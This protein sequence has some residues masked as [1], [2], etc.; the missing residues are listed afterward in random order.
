MFPS[1]KSA[2]KPWLAKV[3]P[4]Q[5]FI[6]LI[7]SGEIRLADSNNDVM[8]PFESVLYMENLYIK[9]TNGIIKVIKK[10]T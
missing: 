7:E 1:E 2:F 10:S 8:T 5:M 4:Y 3:N 6:E 9:Y